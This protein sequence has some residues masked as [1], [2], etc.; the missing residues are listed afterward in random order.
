MTLS[1]DQG[2]SSFGT[3]CLTIVDEI[4]DEEGTSGIERRHPSIATGR[5]WPNVALAT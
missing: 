1:E 2:L 5:P 4:R 3:R